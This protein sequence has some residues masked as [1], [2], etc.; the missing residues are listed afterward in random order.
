MSQSDAAGSSRNQPVLRAR[1]LERVYGRGSSAF[2][3]LRGVDL[4]VPRG[5]SLAVVGKSG[6]G[7]STLMHVLAL[8]DRPTAGEIE[9][10]GRAASRLKPRELNPLR[11]KTFGFV[12]QQFFLTPG[13]TVAENVSL[14]LV[15]AGVPARERRRR[16]T[17]ALEA[18]DLADKAGN[19]ATD[20]SGGQKQ[21]AVIARAL[22][23]EPSVIFADEPTGNLDSTTGAQVED[24]LFGLQR[25]RGITLVVVTHDPDLAARCDGAVTMADGRVIERTG[26]AA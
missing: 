26:V 5:R 1:A 6:S 9:V 16:T 11:N 13:Q 17:A 12:F 25:D 10:D 2:T 21:R 23:N 14:P 18:L 20:L 15:I 22:V 7:K 19:K 8:L 3:A 4:D 24:I